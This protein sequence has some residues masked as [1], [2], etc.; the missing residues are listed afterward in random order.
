MISQ[1]KKK[2]KPIIKMN[3][4]M[5]NNFKIKNHFINNKV[6]FYFNLDFY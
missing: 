1:Y 3:L 5:K 6:V 2:L 4:E